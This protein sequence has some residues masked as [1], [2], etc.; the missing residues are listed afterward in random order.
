MSLLSNSMTL[1]AKR[2]Y[3]T[4]MDY[5]GGSGT[6]PCA[7][8]RSLIDHAS[9]LKARLPVLVRQCRF[10]LCCSYYHLNQSQHEWLRVMVL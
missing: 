9:V 2:K 5:S 7:A 10:E 8:E 6:A 1:H 4:G 3:V